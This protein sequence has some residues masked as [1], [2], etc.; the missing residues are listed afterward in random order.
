MI[1]YESR[2]ITEHH[3]H[4]DDSCRHHL[5]DYNRRR[6]CNEGVFQSRKLIFEDLRREA[7][8]E[9]VG[10]I[11]PNTYELA[12]TSSEYGGGTGWR[13]KIRG[14]RGDEIVKGVCRFKDLKWAFVNS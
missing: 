4:S 14:R 3:L 2:L 6:I 5:A 10:A 1:E 13:G 9:L 8:G 11:R 7:Q 12:L